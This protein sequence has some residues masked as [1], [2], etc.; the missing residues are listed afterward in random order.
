M[1]ASIILL[2]TK[3]LQGQV[4]GYQRLL[5][6]ESPMELQ[7][8]LCYMPV[9]QLPDIARLILLEQKGRLMRP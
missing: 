9:I 8:W 3:A 6:H 7:A 2:T 1:S 5:C 4:Y